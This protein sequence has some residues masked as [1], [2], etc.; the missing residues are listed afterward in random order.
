[1]TS[2]ITRAT[3]F[4]EALAVPAASPANV[5]AGAPPALIWFNGA[6]VPWASATVHV[7]T[8][9]LHYG[10]SVFEG[11]RCYDTARGP[12]LFRAREHLRRLRDSARLYRMDLPLDDEGLL[13]ACRGVVRAASRS[14][15]R[16]IPWN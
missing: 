13:E 5:P 1:M 16:N 3:G 7:M 4:D 15:P 9:A 6:L 2:T 8:H 14:A 10:S 12:A 11:M